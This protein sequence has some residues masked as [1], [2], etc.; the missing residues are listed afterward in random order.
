MD[1]EYYILEEKEQKGPFTF[2]QLKT[3]G[4]NANTLVWTDGMENWKPLKE[5]T[6]LKD[7]LKK[8]PPPPPII[9]N[10]KSSFVKNDNNDVIENNNLSATENNLKFWAT[11]KIYSSIILLIC[12]SSLLVLLYYSN[13]K[14]KLKEEILSKIERIF[15]NKTVILDGE[16]TRVQGE[17]SNTG[18]TGRHVK[19]GNS[20]FDIEEWYE[21]D[22]I[23]T[24]FECKNGGFNLKKLTKL[25]NDSYEL[26]TY[27]SGNMGYKKP[28]SYI[29]VTGW[30]Y[31]GY[32]ESKTYGKINNNRMS[33]QNCYNEAFDFFTV[34][35]KTGA[36]TQG[37]FID[38]SN[39][40]DIRNEYF[41]LEN[42]IPKNY[43][44]SG[45]YGKTW[46]SEG[47]GI[48]NDNWSVYYKK[49]GEH[50]EI[51]ENESATKK[52]LLI[53]FSSVLFLMFLC[54][55][56]IYKSKPNYFRNLNLFGKR[57]RNNSYPEQ[58]IFF[59]HSFFSEHTFT[60]IINDKVC[61]GVLKITDK[62]NTI[63]LSYPNKELF[64]K[65]DEINLDNLSLTSQ[66]D[67]VNIN[68]TRIGAKPTITENQNGNTLEV[69]NNI[70][71]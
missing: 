12:L 70:V 13:K 4:L 22:K 26:E 33:V 18:Y 7:L 50:Y 66:I 63:N 37:K 46:E 24:V 54:L 62:G 68:F 17:L 40:Q 27:Y 23:Y 45:H 35:D 49:Y 28:S 61:K 3:F 53:Y 25:N 10:L 44:S 57:W 64:Y 51:T 2:E 30:N 36:Y 67:G 31:D 71:E 56:I 42:T 5:I 47:G 58:V 34:E 29:G 8:T 60:E 15:E 38:I 69:E 59:E 41:Y 1:K 11:F 65:I 55:F 43:S 9:D 21:K 14:V 39:F 32:S 16:K 52:D 6:E 20:I 19:K 48:S